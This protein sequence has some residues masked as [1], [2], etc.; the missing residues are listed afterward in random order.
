MQGK[1]FLE[2]TRNRG[3]K[4]EPEEA[5]PDVKEDGDKK[6][7]TSIHLVRRAD[8]LCEYSR[9]AFTPDADLSDERRFDQGIR[10]ELEGLPGTATSRPARPFRQRSKQ[11][12]KRQRAS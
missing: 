2:N 12:S 4:H 10:G 5:K 9:L 3:E 7:P 6:I 11:A 8:Y 1:F